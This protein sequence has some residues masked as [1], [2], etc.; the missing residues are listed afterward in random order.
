MA[1]EAI[2]SAML[3][4]VAGG[5]CYPQFRPQNGTL[6][7]C[8]WSVISL[9]PLSR[10]SQSVGVGLWQARVQVDCVASSFAD[11][12]TLADSVQSAM[13]LQSGTYA[14]SHVSSSLLDQKSQIAVDQERSQHIQPIDFLITFY[15]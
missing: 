8:V 12:L 4:G 15:N 14:G 5:R 10:I 2:V 7:A 9:I 11:V 3:T 6:P 1:I 13:H